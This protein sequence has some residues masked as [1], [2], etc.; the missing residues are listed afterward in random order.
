MGLIFSRQCEYAIQAVLYL[1]LKEPGVWASINELTDPL[2][3]PPHFLAKTLQDL[4]KKNI[5]LSLKGPTGGFALARPADGIKLLEVVKAIDGDDLFEKC[6]MGFPDC[7][8]EAPCAVH[9]LHPNSPR[10]LN[11]STELVDFVN[12]ALS[13]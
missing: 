5:L 13:P 8:S 9:A 1:A 3:T 6:A 2:G 10:Q 11:F 12:R 4:T 7:S